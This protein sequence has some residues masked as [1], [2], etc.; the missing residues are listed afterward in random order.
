MMFL[1]WY[2]LIVRTSES[3]EGAAVH[4]PH[5]LTTS[6]RENGVKWVHHHLLSSALTTIAP[7]WMYN[8]VS[9]FFFRTADRFS[10]LYGEKF[11]KSCV[12]VVLISSKDCI[13][14]LAR[15]KS[16]RIFPR[17]ASRNFSYDI[18]CAALEFSESPYLLFRSWQ[19]GR[20]LYFTI[21]NIPV[22]G[23]RSILTRKW[24]FS[25]SF[26]IQI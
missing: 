23:R 9:A 3:R 26:N 12:P 19:L 4:V 14:Q 16:A 20:L 2:S 1:T 6:S 18:L 5:F 10:C 8:A 17:G 21:Q 7:L 22:R 11:A 25:D 15:G 13:L 24:A